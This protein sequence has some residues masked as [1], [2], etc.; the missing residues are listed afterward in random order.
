MCAGCPSQVN[1]KTF[2]SLFLE[3]T[4][5][6]Y[7]PDQEATIQELEAVVISSSNCTTLSIAAKIGLPLNILLFATTYLLFSSGIK[8]G[9]ARNTTSLFFEGENLFFFFLRMHSSLQII[10]GSSIASDLP[11]WPEI[12]E[13]SETLISPFFTQTLG[14]NCKLQSSQSAV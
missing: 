1:M 12:E 13:V 8:L 7:F 5:V 14:S 11:F 3:L 10:L 6:N 4:K 2:W 9:Y